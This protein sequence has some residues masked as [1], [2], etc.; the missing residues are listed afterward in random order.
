MGDLLLADG[1]RKKAAEQYCEALTLRE[2]LAARYPDNA[3]DANELA[4]FL[5][6]CADP[7]FRNPAR[8][9]SFAQKAVNQVRQNGGFWNTLGMAQ[10]RAGQWQK[11]VTALEKAMALGKGGNSSD[12]LFLAMAHW[13]L[14]EKEAA[15]RW[16][17]KAHKELKKF[18]YPREQEGRWLAE[19]ATLL[20]FKEPKK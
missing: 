19:A 11:A 6:V 7:R 12:W 9:V 10:Y 2:G 8:A 15:R 1:E 14:G 3:Q 17:D 20:E 16:Y 18:E 5:A 4:W 13:Q